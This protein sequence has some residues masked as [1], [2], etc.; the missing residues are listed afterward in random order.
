MRLLRELVSQDVIKATGSVHTCFN[1]GANI[2]S[3]E[4]IN[5]IAE[6]NYVG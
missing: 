5:G 3:S 6:L 2:I 1:S 4:K